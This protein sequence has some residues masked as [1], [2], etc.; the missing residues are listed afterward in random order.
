MATRGR[1]AAS[2]RKSGGMDLPKLPIPEVISKPN[3][4]FKAIPPVATI[5]ISLV[6]L[7]LERWQESLQ[8]GLIGLGLA[9]HAL[10]ENVVPIGKKAEPL[11]LLLLAA[12]GALFGYW[13]FE[14]WH[15]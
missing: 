6:Y 11:A 15:G 2:H 3:W 7:R 12:G 4:L 10:P 8:W 1:S 13:V 5:T 14:Q 9:L